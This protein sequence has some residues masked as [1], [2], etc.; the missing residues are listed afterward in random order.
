MPVCPYCGKEIITLYS[1]Q[2]R[3]LVW[4][5]GKW[6]A[7]ISDNEA[8]VTCSACYEEIGPRDLDKLGVPNVLR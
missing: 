7:D 4:H 5:D 2:R 3:N 1:T 8:A 6:L